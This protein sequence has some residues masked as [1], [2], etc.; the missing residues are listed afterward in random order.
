MIAT[1]LSDLTTAPF[2]T[3]FFGVLNAFGPQ[4]GGL[5]QAT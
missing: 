5:L 1:T 3:S 2:K 4:T